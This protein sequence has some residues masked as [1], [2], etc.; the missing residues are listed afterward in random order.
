MIQL[1]SASEVGYLASLAIE[2]LV[3]AQAAIVLVVA[4]GAGLG[5][6]QLLAIFT[7]LAIP[8]V[9]EILG[10]TLP[11]LVAAGLVSGSFSVS[12]TAVAGIRTVLGISL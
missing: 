6:S 8:G 11:V 3:I 7:T 12:A 9:I 10:L 4:I 5:I 2:P 1:G